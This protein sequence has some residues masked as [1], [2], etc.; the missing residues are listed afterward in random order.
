MFAEMLCRSR[1]IV[2]RG[3]G[4]VSALTGVA[5][6][7]RKKARFVIVQLL[8]GLIVAVAAQAAFAQSWNVSS[9]SWEDLD[10]LEPQWCPFVDHRR[11]FQLYGRLHGNR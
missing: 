3:F 9:G 7:G 8:V 11:H 5:V 4:F 6:L 2:A 1:G 10:R